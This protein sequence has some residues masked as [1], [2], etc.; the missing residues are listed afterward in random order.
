MAFA[1]VI[2][3]HA[4]S[5][6]LGLLVLASAGTPA[7]VRRISAILGAGALPD[8]NDALMHQHKLAFPAVVTRLG[9]VC[10]ARTDASISIDP[11]Q[12]TQRH[13][14]ETRRALESRWSKP[15]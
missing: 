12:A 5:D 4:V 2:R 7:S 3:D 1:T 14:L 11:V 10:A 15:P 6:P 8:D 9:D 13:L